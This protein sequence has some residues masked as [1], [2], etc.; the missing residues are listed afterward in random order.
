MARNPTFG[1]V[2]GGEERA[3]EQYRIGKG[4]LSLEFGL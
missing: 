1:V 4:I 2:E 3:E